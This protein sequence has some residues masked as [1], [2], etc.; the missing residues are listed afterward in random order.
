MSHI[1][2]PPPVNDGVNQ[3]TVITRE[4]LYG[5]PTKPIRNSDANIYTYNR[6]KVPFI[7]GLKMDNLRYN[8]TVSNLNPVRVMKPVGYYLEELPKA[9]VPV[10]FKKEMITE[11]SIMNPPANN[12]VQVFQCECTQDFDGNFFVIKS[13]SK[14]SSG[15]NT[16]I[17]DFP[18]V[19]TPNNTIKSLFEDHNNNNNENNMK[20]PDTMQTSPYPYNRPMVS[21]NREDDSREEL[22]LDR[23]SNR[24]PETYPQK[25]EDFSGGYSYNRP[26]NPMRLPNDLR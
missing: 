1:L 23:R 16:P 18:S 8:N 3:I 4:E 24:I 5:P 15:E 21:F 17:H 10:K 12:A 22:D 9:D 19:Q 6:P 13:N 11:P 14:K 20:T 26:K 25:L 7:N 2:T